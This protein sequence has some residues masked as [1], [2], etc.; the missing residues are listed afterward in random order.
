MKN[1]FNSKQTSIIRLVFISLLLL[2]A[3]VFGMDAQSNI[4]E[5]ATKEQPILMKSREMI[6]PLNLESEGN[7]KDTFK[8]WAKSYGYSVEWNTKKNIVFINKIEYTGDFKIVLSSLARDIEIMGKDINFKVFN[9]N[10]VIV[11]YS[12]R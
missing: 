4:T 12:V 3:S 5:V 1:T 2:S 11:V 7:L 9:K 10:K 8:I 6:K